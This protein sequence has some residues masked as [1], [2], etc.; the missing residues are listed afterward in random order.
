MFHVLFA[1]ASTGAAAMPQINF[2]L[3]WVVWKQIKKSHCTRETNSF[4]KL[5]IW[6]DTEVTEQ[7]NSLHAEPWKARAELRQGLR[8]CRQV[9]LCAPAWAICSDGEVWVVKVHD[10]KLVLYSP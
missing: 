9:C 8:F 3:S 2:A 6:R 1:A 4:L 10:V 5:L 7:G